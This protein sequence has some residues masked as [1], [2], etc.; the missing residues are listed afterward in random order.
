MSDCQFIKVSVIVPI[1][2][3]EEYLERCIE[4][5]L[6]QTLK[7]IEVILVNDGSPDNSQAIIDKYTKEY[8][9]KVIGLVKENGG[10]SDA[11]NY[12]IPYAKGEYI[13]FVD[14]DDYV[15]ITMYEKLYNK[16]IETDSEIVTCGYYGI[17]ENKENYRYF[18]KG[19]MIQYGKNLSDN[20]KL[21][22]TNAPYAW[23][24]IYK[25]ELF[26]RTGIRFPKGLIYEDIAT[27]YPLMM[28]ANRISKV[29]EALVYYILKREGAITATFSK[30]ILQM[31]KALARMNDLYIESGKFDEFKE[32]LGFINLKHTI[33]RFRDFT[34]YNDHKLQREMVKEGFHQL[35]TYFPDW[36]SNETFFDFYFKNKRLTKL[37][38]KHKY[39]WELYI[40]IPNPILIFGKKMVQFVK[41]FKKV[42][43]KKSYFN[44]YYYV[45]CCKKKEL[46]E[47]QVLFE[48]FHGTTLSD[49]PFAM[50]Q[51]LAKE[52]KY[53]IYY[54][55]N[56]D[57][58]G[59]HQK[60][61]NEYNLDVHL[62]VLGSREYQKVLACSKY[63]V[64][65][66]SF[67]TYFMRRKG[68]E[69][70]NTWHGTPLKT[71][72]KRMANGIQDMSNMQ[73]NFLESTY[74]LHPN[75][76]TMDHMMEDYN[77]NH[78]YTGKVLLEG[79]PRNSVFLDKDSE[80]RIRK[81]YKMDEKEV[82]AYMP[83]WRGAMSS[84]ANA[85]SYEEEVLSILDA[86]DV[87]LTDEQIF[88]VNL[89]PL[90]KNKVSIDGYKHIQT[91]PDDVNSYDFLN[92]VDILI[93]DYSSV[94]FDY[95]ITKKPIVL[96]MYDYD[97]Y[98]NERGMYIDVKELPFTKIYNLKN[99]LSYLSLKDKSI[100][101]TKEDYVLYHDKFLKYDTLDSIA[102][103]NNLFFHHVNEDV[104][105]YDYAKNKEIE[106]T[107][108]LAPQIKH[109]NNYH[110]LEIVDDMV[111]PVAVFLRREFTSHTIDIL[112]KKYNSY[113]DYI[114]VDTHMHLTFR[115]N[116]YLFFCRESK[117]YKVNHLYRREVERL[118]PDI[119][120]KKVVTANDT[121][122]NIS[123][124][125]S[126]DEEQR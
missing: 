91:F 109:R 45:N 11:R 38:S 79:Y 49:S 110:K 60:L 72:G 29:D 58:R 50:M 68:Q 123:I 3:V 46:V 30:N 34:L 24:K 81:K 77:L 9:D 89:H 116:V 69:Y 17:D 92:A 94:F 15:D 47:N 124:K 31:Y 118:L 20:P 90:V 12:G 26:E 59:E 28:Y 102:H 67:P 19:N 13:G 18:Q 25:K 35:H 36:R 4:S 88:Y 39:I 85:N 43:T 7:E 2:N 62:V 82:F 52:G 44:K 105:I 108:Y 112:T 5:L 66:V 53:K 86:I 48:S 99:M 76:F 100:D 117:K 97:T 33:L 8:P 1:Y 71:L 32:V 119:K 84:G 55:T 51:D 57:Q 10:L 103:I 126:I 114:V 70:L 113:L 16:A 104:E 125:K 42:L 6:H 73:R 98:M 63:L 14:S 83:T 115:E 101:Y 122:R 75:K 54:T 40:L 93:T 74:L 27:I 80:Q 65:N 96:F 106:H 56:K 21:L 121:F 95:S 120:I 61:L 41:K 64:N 87:T 22:Y 37:F 78:L 107:L 111:N 23:N